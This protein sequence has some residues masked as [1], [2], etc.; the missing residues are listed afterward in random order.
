MSRLTSNISITKPIQWNHTSICKSI[1]RLIFTF[2]MVLC[3][4]IFYFMIKWNNPNVYLVIFVKV[5]LTECLISF[6]LFFVF[7]V[8]LRWLKLSNLTLFFM[9]RESI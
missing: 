8:I 7:K 3:T 2:I 5:C 1:F 4:G 9:L 6:G